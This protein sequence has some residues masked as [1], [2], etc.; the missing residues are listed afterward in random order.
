MK[1]KNEIYI[2]KFGEK[3]TVKFKKGRV[4][5]LGIKVIG[6]AYISKEWMAQS[7]GKTKKDALKNIKQI[8]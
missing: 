4:F 2:N 6:D 3:V 7:Y 1:I 5:S 8:I